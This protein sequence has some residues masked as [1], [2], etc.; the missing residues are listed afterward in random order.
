M[1]PGRYA[2]V[3]LVFST[4]AFGQW[5]SHQYDAEYKAC[6]S[7]CE[8]NPKIAASRRSECAAACRCALDEYQKRIPDYAQLSRELRADIPPFATDAGMMI[9]DMCNAR[10]FGTPARAPRSE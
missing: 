5:T 2:I 6:V 4:S 7:G 1:K 9:V 8:K 3:A 10:V